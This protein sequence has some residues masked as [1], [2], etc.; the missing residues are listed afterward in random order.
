MAAPLRN[1]LLCLIS[2]IITISLALATPEEVGPANFQKALNLSINGMKFEDLDANGFRSEGE[3]GLPGWTIRLKQNGTDLL[4][5]TTDNAGQYSFSNLQPGRYEILEDNMP[6]WVQTAPGGGSYLVTLTDKPAYNLDF[7]NSR[8]KNVSAMPSARIYPVMRPTPEEVRRWTDQYKAAPKAYLSPKLQTELALAPGTTFNL[9]DYMEYIPS[10]RDQG[11]C[12]NCWAWAGTGAMEI[13]NAFQNGIEDRL[14]IQYLNSNFHG[15]G[16]SNWA[17]CGGWLGDVAD[18]YSSTGLAVPWSNANAHW[19]DGGRF[20][21]AHSTSVPAKSISTNPSYALTSIQTQVVPTQGVGKEAAIANIKNVLHQG[22]AVWFGYFL[23]NSA[24]WSDF[25]SFWE[26]ET[27][28]AIWQ[29]DFA[30]GESYSYASGAGHAVLCVGYDDTDPNNRYWII[31]NSWGAPA[32]RPNGLFRMNMD[33]NYDC[34]YPNFGFAFYW[35]V[36][37]IAYPSGPNNP[38]ATPSVPS[39]P[40]S[41]YGG[42]S[43]SYSTSSTDPDGDDIKYTFDWGDGTSSETTLVGSG[44]STSASHSWKRIGTYYVRAR[45]VDSK[46]TS[47][48][49]SS[50][51]IVRISSTGLN[52]PPIKPSKPSGPSVGHTGI[53]YRYRT[54]ATDPNGDE[55]IYIIDWGDGSSSEAGPTR[56]G[57]SIEVG[58]SWTSPGTY[59]IRAE[60]RDDKGGSSGWSAS[61]VVTIV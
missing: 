29:P 41:G 44:M 11:Y 46:G 21:E 14:S 19:Q 49:W 1:P 3:P 48:G 7:G 40:G 4:N 57:R 42:T 37:D 54:Y 60:A 22:K 12:G 2:L 9:M 39:G 25:T 33:M 50:S 24:A 18:F 53:L 13:D 20:C 28:D 8:A 32:N 30:C 52:N 35:M 17:C 56:A 15:G 36:L 61:A 58:H 23:P 6:E 47:S 26:G 38:P 34:N 5:A 31:L 10:E 55:L 27:E 59:T 45:A 16:G 43:Y 51:L